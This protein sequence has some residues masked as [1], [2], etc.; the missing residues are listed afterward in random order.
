MEIVLIAAVAENGVIGRD[1]GLPWRLSTDMQRFKAT[2]MGKP[3][4]MGRKTWESFPRKPLPGRLNIVVSRDPAYRADGAE[5][6]TS[7]DDALKIAQ[8][9][10]ADAGAIYV[11][12]GGEL[13]R[14]AIGLA[15]RLDIT[16]VHASPEGDTRFPAID[17]REWQEVRADDYPAGEKDSHATR[18]V[19]YERRLRAPDAA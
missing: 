2:T 10:N 8:G 3:V 18:H 1:N 13:Y 15:D 16:H 4:V 9:R 17:P 7:L 14:Q 12:G 5:T 6:A 11:V 19:V